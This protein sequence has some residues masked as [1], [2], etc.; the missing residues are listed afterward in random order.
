MHN[1]TTKLNTYLCPRSSTHRFAHIISRKVQ[2][3]RAVSLSKG[4]WMPNQYAIPSMCQPLWRCWYL[5]APMCGLWNCQYAKMT[6]CEFWKCQYAEMS[7]CGLCKCLYAKVPTCGLHV[8]MRRWQCVDCGSV[9]MRRP[10]VPMCRLWK[11]QYV[12][13]QMCGGTKRGDANM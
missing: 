2:I 10:G 8:N 1:I 13:V 11:C 7:I 9:N 12:E 6:M 3:H 5:D 4:T